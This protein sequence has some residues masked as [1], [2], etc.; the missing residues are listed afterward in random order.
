MVANGSLWFS[1]GALLG[2][3]TIML[4]NVT[5]IVMGSAYCATFVKYRSPQASIA[6][7]AAISGGLIAATVGAT[8]LLPT[9]DA[10]NAIGWTA[11]GVC[12]GMFGGPLASIR[13]VLRDRSAASLPLGFTLF[14]IANTSVWLAYGLLVLHDPF[15][16]GPNVL[17]L[18][19]LAAQ[20][21]LIVRFGSGPAAGAAA[22]A[23]VAAKL[24]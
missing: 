22:G 21:G 24:K 6:P 7:H 10:L 19:A 1:Y 20:L 16:W 2:N 11:C 23:A 17:G 13:A 4:P 15:I 5:A 8:Q 12:V 9:A 14:S 3:P 18:A